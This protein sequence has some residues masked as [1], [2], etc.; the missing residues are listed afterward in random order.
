ML[1]IRIDLSWRRTVLR[2]LHR[3]FSFGCGWEKIEFVRGV[4]WIWYFNRHKP[5]MA[6]EF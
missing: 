5:W 3:A 4:N 6:V 2:V 1:N